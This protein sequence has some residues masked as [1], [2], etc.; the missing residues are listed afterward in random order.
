MSTRRRPN[1][2]ATAVTVTVITA[3]PTKVNRV[4]LVGNKISPGNP[5]IKNDGTVVK[6][7]WGEL[8]WQLGTEQ[9]F[10]L[11]CRECRSRLIHHQNARILRQRLGDFHRLLLRDPKP[12]DGGACIEV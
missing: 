7:L 8:A 11:V 1:R 3:L 10:D 6:T 5:S 2:S 12:M 4:V 9:A